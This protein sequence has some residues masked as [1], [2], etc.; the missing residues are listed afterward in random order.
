M[1]LHRIEQCRLVIADDDPIFRE[2]LL[3]M[4]STDFQPLAVESGAEAIEIIEQGPVDLALFDMH[5]PDV[6]GLEA[7]QRIR[8]VRE[9]L[10]CLLMTAR[11]SDQLVH[12]AS[13]V[14]VETVLKKPISRR[15]LISAL[16]D[17]LQK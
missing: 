11:Y 12:Q 16:L 5:M 6:T 9:D 7:I 14:N 1:P 4:L 15:R 17:A 10:P 8:Q 2:T 3:D 13:E